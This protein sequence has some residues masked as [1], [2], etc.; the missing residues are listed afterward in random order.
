MTLPAARGTAAV[1][2]ATAGIVTGPTRSIGAVTG[3]VLPHVLRVV[4]D[5]ADGAASA[6]ARG[7]P[8]AGA[9]RSDGADEPLVHV[10]HVMGTAVVFSVRATDGPAV[11]GALAEACR[12]LHRADAVFSTWDPWS[13]MSRLRRGAARLDDLDD[14]DAAEIDAVLRL[15]WR[16]RRASDGWFDPWAV[17]GGVDPTGLVKGWALERA[18]AVLAGT[19]L[20]AMVN[21]GGDVVICGEPPA[22]GSWRIGVRHPWLRDGL[23]CVVSVGGRS[24]AVASSASYER[25]AHFVDPRTGQRT[26]GCLASATVTGTD[27]AVADALATAVAVGGRAVADRVEAAGCQAYGIGWDG[28]EWWTGGFPFA[29]DPRPAAQP[30]PAA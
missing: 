28:Q 1:G 23:A 4:P 5:R 21:G 26:T 14:L 6:P 13:P 12:L 22:G 29:D 8:G 2:R 27:L 18:A 17:P 24:R 15:C 16:A 19:G 3:V 9:P 11:S 20:P 7:S 30:G 25:G 10:E